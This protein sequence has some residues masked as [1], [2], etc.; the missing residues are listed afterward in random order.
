MDFH[1]RFLNKVTKKP[2]PD[3]LALLFEAVLGESPAR[4]RELA[5]QWRAFRSGNNSF[6]HRAATISYQESVERADAIMMQDK[7]A[8]QHFL[9]SSD[10]G[11]VLLTIH[12]G[13]FLHSILKI[14]MLAERRRV[15]ILRRQSWSQEEESAFEKLAILGHEVETIRHG[16]HASRLVASALRSGAIA[17]LLYDLPCRWGKTSAV[18]LFNRTCHWVV[19]PLQLAMLGKA[20]VIPFFSYSQDQRSYCDLHQVIDY[21]HVTAGRSALLREDLQR[22][23]RTA[24]IYIRGHAVQWD[25]WF[26]MPEMLQRERHD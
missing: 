12:M 3:E 8:L 9:N 17:I 4:S 22:M 11:V 21:R 13:D 1:R 25:H 24:E 20:T 6:W 19:G 23:A 15:V 2:Q 10:D 18:Q 5:V 14:L 7:S 16:T 26:L